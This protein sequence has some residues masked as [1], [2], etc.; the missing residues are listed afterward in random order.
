VCYNIIE[1][2]ERMAGRMNKQRMID[3]VV[4]T[5]GMENEMT[6][7]FFRMA[8]DEEIEFEML[9]KMYYHIMSMKYE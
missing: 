5:C 8:E 6:I 4:R 3:N 7:L 9:E 2:K 1:V